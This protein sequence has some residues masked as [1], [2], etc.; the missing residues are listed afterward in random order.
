MT[1]L[2]VLHLVWTIIWQNLLFFLLSMEL[3]RCMDD[4]DYFLLISSRR[5]QLWVSDVG[6]TTKENKFS[7]FTVIDLA[8]ILT[9]CL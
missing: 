7:S 4:F 6:N 2:I 9:V 1:I 5:N 8:Y 3:I